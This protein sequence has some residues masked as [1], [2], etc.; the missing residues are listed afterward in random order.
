MSNTGPFKRLNDEFY[1]SSP[2][3]Y[4][5]DRLQMLVLRGAN[6]NVIDENLGA[7][8][9]WGQLG[10]MALESRAEGAEEAA[11]KQAEHLRFLVT[12]S[13]VL[14]HHAAE[15]LLR[16]YLAHEA[17]AECPWLEIAASKDGR[18]FRED[19]DELARST[20]DRERMDAAG[21]VFLGGVPT[22]PTAEWTDAR[23]AAVRLLRVLAQTVNVES[24]LYNAAKHGATALGGAGS[25][26]FLASEPGAAPP[27]IT[28]KLLQDRAVLG[29][30]D[31]NVAYLE[32][33]GTRKH[34][35]WFHKTQWVNP[36]RAA[37]LAQ[38]AIVQM[39][40]LWIVARWRAQVC[41]TSTSNASGST[42]H[43]RSTSGCMRARSPGA[44]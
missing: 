1:A 38:L 19:L 42:R 32:R 40:A 18:R 30:D 33:E 11:E 7:Q 16:M 13:Q 22:Q 21:W 39:E 20:W 29:A 26:H 5:R 27:E 35:T 2:S 15:T 10:V 9:T 41:S 3:T 28:A 4:F 23:D 14:L 8:T 34:G 36:E 24:Q 37:Y 44:P 43:R 31:V 6:P 12:E 17:R 25:I